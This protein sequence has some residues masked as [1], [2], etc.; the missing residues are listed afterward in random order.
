[1][2]QPTRTYFPLPDLAVIRPQNRK[3]KNVICAISCEYPAHIGNNGPKSENP[4][5]LTLTLEIYPVNLPQI[6]FQDF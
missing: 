4:A 5:V 1:M 2:R 6:F 3:I